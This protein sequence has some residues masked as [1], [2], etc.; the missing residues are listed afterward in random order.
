M[1]QKDLFNTQDSTIAKGNVT[2][3]E[4]LLGRNW[5]VYMP[6]EDECHDWFVVQTTNG[7]KLVLCDIYSVV[8]DGKLS[9]KYV[10]VKEEDMTKPETIE[11]YK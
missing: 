5:V 10:A 7:S 8:I 1:E 11:C 6:T 9:T 3:A 2:Q 4:R